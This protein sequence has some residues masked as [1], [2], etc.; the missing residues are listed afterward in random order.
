MSTTTAESTD[1]M[2]VGTLLTSHAQWDEL[3][4]G[5]R[6]ETLSGGG[7][8]EKREDGWWDEVAGR[9]R[10]VRDYF[11]ANSANKITY[12]PVVVRVGDELRGRV[13]F[14]RCP[15]GTS[16]TCHSNP[17][18]EFRKEALNSWVQ[19]NPSRSRRRDD[20]WFSEDHRHTVLSLP[21]GVSV[22]TVNSTGSMSV[23]SVGQL[24][25]LDV[26]SLITVSVP[27]H[28]KVTW[29]TIGDGMLKMNDGGAE[30]PAVHFQRAVEDGHVTIGVAPEAGQFYHE[31]GTGYLLVQRAAD[32][33]WYIVVFANS[34]WH[35]ITRRA[36]PP[37]T[38]ATETPEWLT[39][40][41]KSLAGAVVAKHVAYDEM[42][43]VAEDR[44]VMITKQTEAQSALRGTLAQIERGKVK[45]EDLRTYIDRVLSEHGIK[46]LD[47]TVTVT[48][49]V[50]ITQYVRIPGDVM[51]PHIKDAVDDSTVNEA[52]VPVVFTRKFDTEVTVEPGACGCRL[53]GNPRLRDWVREQGFRDLYAHTITAKECTSE[54]CQAKNPF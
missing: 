50:A 28:A 11:N 14:A 26:N 15:I 42:V 46:A 20:R 32:G 54:N 41:L 38:L 39:D 45:P 5:T 47:V 18:K 52:R 13:A 6:L 24:A 44:Q 31:G 27:G 9:L 48:S 17:T 8:Y 30:L 29:T 19:V 10:N 1:W 7:R 2:T 53:V 3:P 49:T 23:T 33:R 37:G 40:S 25:G 34:Q 4:V 16:I 21:N 22:L 36:D 12:L 35:S 51:K 43:K